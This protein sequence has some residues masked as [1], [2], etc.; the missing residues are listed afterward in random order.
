[1]TGHQHYLCNGANKR[2]STID[3][4]EDQSLFAAENGDEHFL[5]K[6][7]SCLDLITFFDL[8]S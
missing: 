5:F 3:C 1:L 7:Y 2:P 4:N 8:D 6:L